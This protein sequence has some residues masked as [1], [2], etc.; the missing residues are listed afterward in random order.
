MLRLGLKSLLANKIRFALTASTITIGVAFVVA[1]FVTADSLRATFDELAEDISTGTDFTVRSELPFGDLTDTNRAPV[2]ESL[3][4]DI[5]AIEGVD[6]AVGGLFVNGVIPVDGSGEAVTSNG[7][8][9]AGSN[10]TEDESL[11]QWFLIAGRRPVGMSEFALDRGTFEKYDF[12]LDSEYEVVTPVGPRTFTLVGTMQ[13]GFPEDAGVGATFVLFDTPTA[14]AVLGY[15]GEFQQIAIRAE[16]GTDF[17]ALQSRIETQLPEGVEV[18]SAEEASEEFSDALGTVIDFLQL[19]LLVFAFIVI[20]VSTFIISNTFNIVLG[21]RVRELSMLRAVGATPWQIRGSVLTESLA[22][23]VIASGVG[24]AGGMAGSLL[25]RWLFA[26]FAADLPPGPLPLSPRTVIW[27]VAVGVGITVISSLVPAVKASRLSPMAGLSEGHGTS[28]GQQGGRLRLVF[29]GLLLALG[30]ALTGFGL[31]GSFDGATPRLTTLAVGA[32]LVFIAVAVLSPFVAGT[33]ASAVIRPIAGVLGTAGQL[34]RNNSARNP[35]RTAATA[36]ALTIGLALVTVVLVVGESL[37]SS[38]RDRVSTAVQADFVVASTTQ[39][40]LPQ[41]L[42][43]ELKASGIGTVVPFDFDF[44]QILIR[45]DEPESWE[46]TETITAAEFAGLPAVTDFGVTSGSIDASGT[47]VLVHTDTADDYGLDVGDEVTLRFVTGEE[48]QVAVDALFTN[49]PLWTNWVID[50]T[51]YERFGTAN[52]DQFVL[53]R[54]DIDDTDEARAVMDGALSGYHQAELEDRQ[55]FQDSV[56]SQVDIV[57]V[58]ANVFLGFALLIALIGI[59]NTLTLSVFERTR[60]IGL[61]R[62]VGMSARQL[63]RMIRWEAVAVALY[64]ALLGIGLGLLFGTAMT[65]AIPDDF[66]GT[67][68]VPILWMLI[69][70][71]VAV[72]FGLIAALFPA[73]RA[74]R[75]NVLDAIADEWRKIR[76]EG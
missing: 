27:A 60:E 24:L 61:L 43:H 69:I 41:T 53:V 57:L 32:G 65:I 36:V 45:P 48:T 73:F 31:F 50:R 21:Q 64:G 11:S 22:I 8:P 34:A 76:R 47:G 51:L 3:V 2:A 46:L 42:S 17:D 28:D 49:N 12:E 56:A 66:I 55:E 19:V 29:G 30:L 4:D 9:V 13:F 7:P 54:S 20:F 74:S 58:F 1:A 16:A 68:S 75:M 10:W 33:I 35:R 15:E 67:T 52:F 26:V 72:A 18:I 71:L 59:V 14:Q 44:A 38:F 5:A 40:G 39:T 23:G 37:K 63:R 6:N 62:A 70:L 25:I